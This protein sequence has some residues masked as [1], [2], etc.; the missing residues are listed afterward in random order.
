[1]RTTSTKYIIENELYNNPEVADEVATGV[2]S[3]PFQIVLDIGI[4][5]LIVHILFFVFMW[6]SIRK[7]P[8]S[9]LFLSTICLFAIIGISGME[10]LIRKDSLILV[11]LAFAAVV[12]N[13]KRNIGGFEL[14]PVRDGEKA[15]TLLS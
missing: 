11:G 7:L 12:L 15:P 9:G 8:H 3:V 13:D 10:G 6:L 4:L 1:M 2:E 14:P 5:G